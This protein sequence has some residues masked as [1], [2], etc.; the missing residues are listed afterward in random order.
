VTESSL[1]PV[2][3]SVLQDESALERVLGSSPGAALERMSADYLL[4]SIPHWLYV[5]DTPLHLSA[6]SLRGWAA[7]LLLRHAADPN[8]T[9]RRGATPLHYACDP[10]PKAAGTWDPAAQVDII[11]LLVKS[12]ASVNAVDR[13][14]ITPL[15]RAVRARSPHAVRELLRHGA[16]L[17]A[18]SARGATPLQL[19][20]RPTGAS[21][22][23]GTPAEQR[24][25]VDLL[26]QQGARDARER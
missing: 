10:R 17:E 9:N 11:S 24:E 4:E 5:G 2:F 18:R 13:G 22:T 15:H 21:G 19:A 12:G 7:R 26:R 14:G 8:A 20:M 25:I 6:A 23:A 16:R 3:E 1:P